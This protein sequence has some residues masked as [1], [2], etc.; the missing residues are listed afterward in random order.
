ML[1]YNKDLLCKR[2]FECPDNFLLYPLNPSL[3]ENLNLAV[4]VSL[5]SRVLE[6]S[7]L[8]IWKEGI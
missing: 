1:L 3:S 4:F 6:L 7:M 8:S 5:T 2:N